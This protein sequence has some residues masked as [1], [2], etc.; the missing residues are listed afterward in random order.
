MYEMHE[1]VDFAFL[2]NANR[3]AVWE[4]A[5]RQSLIIPVTTGRT[6]FVFTS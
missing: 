2:K 6:C 3:A 5:I 4:I 1:E